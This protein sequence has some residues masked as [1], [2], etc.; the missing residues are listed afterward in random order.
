VKPVSGDQDRPAVPAR[1]RALSRAAGALWAALVLVGSML[2]PAAI[3][4]VM[5][6]FSSAHL[7]AHAGAYVGLGVLV[8]WG[9]P[10]RRWLALAAAAVLLGIAI[11]FAQPLTGRTFDVVDMLVDAA[12]VA[13]GMAAGWTLAGLGRLL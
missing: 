9:W 13:V 4:P 1:G 11:E 10:R 7:M 5:P 6:K 3:E 2:P 12:G 8:V